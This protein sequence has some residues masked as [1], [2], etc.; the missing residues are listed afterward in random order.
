VRT[1][2]SIT[3]GGHGARPGRTALNYFC[4]A[5]GGIVTEMTITAFESERYWLISA[6]AGE[7]HDE[8][9][10]RAHLPGGGA[11]RIDNQSA[12][13]GT[14]IVVGPRSRELLSALTSA[15]LG[16][17]AFPWLAMRTIDIGYTQAIALRVN[18]VGEL[19]WNCICR[20]SSFCRCMNWSGRQASASASA[21][22]VCTRWTA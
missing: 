8:H 20:W 3:C 9:W 2:G 10:L 15:D 22:T 13:Y 18:Y 12:R 6:A 11:V 21:I 19:G 4:S 5:S 17:E 1:P 7:R 16:N 14:L